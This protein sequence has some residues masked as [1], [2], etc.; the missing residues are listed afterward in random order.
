MT[1]GRPT[2]Q[3]AARSLTSMASVDASGRE[4]R[5]TLPTQVHHADGGLD[6][7]TGSP[8][9]EGTGHKE[10]GYLVSWDWG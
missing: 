4:P 3:L 8:S 5:L 6:D 7:E 9:C 1:V 10:V 2:S